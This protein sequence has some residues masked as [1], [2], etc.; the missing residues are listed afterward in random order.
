MSRR[1]VRARRPIGPIATDLTQ[2]CGQTMT[3]ITDTPGH[4]IATYEVNKARKMLREPPKMRLG[5]SQPHTG[6][7]SIRP[8]YAAPHSNGLRHSSGLVVGPTGSHY[9]STRAP[10]SALLNSRGGAS[11]RQEDPMRGRRPLVD[12]HVLQ[13]GA[14][15]RSLIRLEPG[16]PRPVTCG[17]RESTTAA[18]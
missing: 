2:P 1:R 10:K 3:Y 13:S 4:T 11:R 9:H 18:R 12:V 6:K 16:T 15:V 5:Q 8:P 14:R 17:T 7:P